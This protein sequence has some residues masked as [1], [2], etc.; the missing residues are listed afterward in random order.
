LRALTAR[1]TRGIQAVNKF[2]TASAVSFP[3]TQ[4][5]GQMK[6]FQRLGAIASL[7]FVGVGFFWFFKLRLLGTGLSLCVLGLI[8]GPC[9]AMALYLIE[10]RSRIAALEKRCEESK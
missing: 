8:S 7:I 9:L 5:G 6:L 1:P 4:D 3:E 2:L 10:L